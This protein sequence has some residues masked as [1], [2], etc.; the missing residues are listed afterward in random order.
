MVG[1]DDADFV[2]ELAQ[3]LQGDTKKSNF[4]NVW[5]DGK[6]VSKFDLSELDHWE[7]HLSQRVLSGLLLRSE[8]D[9]KLHIKPRSKA[10]KA[11]QAAKRLD[12][13]VRRNKEERKD[14]GVDSLRIGFPLVEFADESCLCP[15]VLWKVKLDVHKGRYVL[16]RDFTDS[17]SLNDAL[18]HFLSSERDIDIRNGPVNDK[19]DMVNDVDIERL[20]QMILRS[21]PGVDIREKL[22]SVLSDRL[23]RVPSG[24]ASLSR[25]VGPRVVWA[26][27]LGLFK[28]GNTS[29]LKDLEEYQRN[30][31]TSLSCERLL[32]ESHL[33]Y[34][35]FP[36]DPS[37]FESLKQLGKEKNVVINGPPGTGKSQTLAGLISCAGA[38]GLKTL[39]VCEKKTPLEI[40]S[41]KLREISW[42][43]WR[44]DKFSVLITNVQEREAVVMQA[45]SNRSDVDRFRMS[46]YVQLDAKL[47]LEIERLQKEI[48]L[49]ER[50]FIKHK[51]INEQAVSFGLSFKE[52]VGFVIQKRLEGKPVLRLPA[53]CPA[54]LHANIYLEVH[55]MA[56]DRC[57]ENI[58]K[59]LISALN[60]VKLPKARFEPEVVVTAAGEL[61]K[62]VR[63]KLEG[64]EQVVRAAK[65]AMVNELATSV[66]RWGNYHEDLLSIQTQLGPVPDDVIQSYD[67]PS[68]LGSLRVTLAFWSSE[69]AKLRYCQSVLSKIYSEIKANEGDSIRFPTS[70]T[71]S[72]IRR[73]ATW[74]HKIKEKAKQELD[75]VKSLSVTQAWE[76]GDVNSSFSKRFDEVNDDIMASISL[77]IFSTKNALDCFRECLVGT[78]DKNECFWNIEKTL[79]A[80]HRNGISVWNQAADSINCLIDL[81]INRD[82]VFFQE[83]LKPVNGITWGEKIKLALLANKVDT[84]CS[85]LITSDYVLDKLNDSL[86]Q[87]Q[88]RMETLFC[89]RQA[90]KMKESIEKFETR[91]EQR[92]E[93]FYNRTSKNIRV[94][95]LREIVKDLELFVA[96]FPVILCTPSVASTLFKGRHKVF[97]LVI[98]DEASQALPHDAYTSLLKGKKVVIAGD[99][100]QMPPTILFNANGANIFDTVDSDLDDDHDDT[101]GSRLRAQTYRNAANAESLLDYATEHSFCFDS[102]KLQFHYRS[103]NPDLMRF[104]CAAIYPD[105]ALC[106]ASST[107][108]SA[109]PA[110]QLTRVNGVYKNQGNTKEAAHIVSL[111]REFVCSREECDKSIAVATFNDVQRKTISGL[112][113][114]ETD[115]VFITRLRELQSKGM[116]FVKNLENLQ[117]DEVDILIVGTT[118]GPTEK[119]T[120]SRC[121]G[122][123]TYSGIGYRYLNVLFSRAKI[124]LHVVT[125]IPKTEY[126]SPE[127]FLD[128]LGTIHGTSFLFGFLGYAN[129]I[130]NND[131]T[132]VDAILR[133]Y[134]RHRSANNLVCNSDEYTCLEDVIFD[135]LSKKSSPHI[136]N[137]T[138]QEGSEHVIR[139]IIV[140]F[141]NQRRLAIECNTYDTYRHSIHRKM[142]LEK[143]GYEYF[144][145]WPANWLDNP[146]R[147]LDKL[148]QKIKDIAR[149][150]SLGPPHVT[151]PEAGI[152]GSNVTA[153]LE[154][155]PVSGAVP[156]VISSDSEYELD[157][158]EVEVLPS[159]SRIETPP[160][161]SIVLRHP[162]LLRYTARRKYIVFIPE[163]W[164]D[165]DKNIVEGK[166][167][168]LELKINAKRLVKLRAGF[169]KESFLDL[170]EYQKAK[171]Y[172]TKGQQESSDS[173]E[174]FE[175]PLSSSGEAVLS[176]KKRSS[177][178]R[179]V[180]SKKR[181]RR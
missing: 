96:C 126:Q 63:S 107:F 74:C 157:V 167:G 90:R 143:F 174:D 68:W 66:E 6:S 69:N 38:N 164:V 105:L 165:V 181:R 152:T 176:A 79:L 97:D 29:I 151:V 55:L 134:S 30:S 18:C 129:A 42:D 111:L 133:E 46:E 169:K 64:R 59:T 51:S 177:S 109:E 163:K 21:T 43:K 170:V 65:Q 31:Q 2:R 85:D 8:V 145:I 80:F 140:K 36:M 3:K 15:L 132:A 159:K 57:E 45:H 101:V 146:R 166:G 48:D 1:R 12:S 139:G 99:N 34:S 47:R 61:C 87:I 62:L 108:L 94:N 147:E 82:D 114:R 84:Q 104:H 71:L 154:N 76:R 37:Q 73:V 130:G 52:A 13:L 95:S 178:S 72:N 121:F 58:P 180:T 24:P 168:L 171:H 40:L 91:T 11:T 23:E 155:E 54:A 138:R 19:K 156:L 86:A 56:L 81:E 14:F 44:G 27:V 9:E 110:I 162:Y 60:L 103:L 93:Q 16:S 4:M 7:G 153:V 83:F 127:R 175:S 100:K 67:S 124:R 160:A 39:V 10:L 161:T 149:K 33:H 32:M 53:S 141:S 26:S 158:D 116:F 28:A 144:Q 118:F 75:A 120:F 142:L 5:C 119:G 49:E 70:F 35:A 148:R 136:A 17:V 123:L 122:R 113:K 50:K 20:V 150:N 41:K 88:Q 128:E 92:F 22:E 131:T 77:T 78:V 25:G 106:P 98:F 117:G 172:L 135:S 115:Q 102:I 89:L 112:L 125:S 173:D 179:R 137:I